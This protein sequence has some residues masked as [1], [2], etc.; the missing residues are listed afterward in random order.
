MP[1]LRE[2][3]NNPVLKPHLNERSIG[4]GFKSKNPRFA[5]VEEADFVEQVERAGFFDEAAR[6]FGKR[7]VGESE[8]AEMHR[9]H[10]FCA[11]FDKRLESLF[12]IHVNIA[13]GRGVVGADGQKRDLDIKAVSDF[14]ESVKIRAVAAVEQCA[15][16]IL[17]DESAEAAVVVVEDACAPVAGGS[18]GDAKGTVLKRFPRLELAD[19]I[20]TKAVNEP[21][22]VLGHGDGLV[23]RDR[24]QG[25]AVEMV[26]VRV[27]DKHKV[28]GR[29]VVNFETRLLDT[30]DDLEPL[31]PIGIDED[32]VLGGL[33]QERG[34]TNPGNADLPGDEVGKRGF[35]FCAVA[36]RE[37]RGYDDLRKKIS[38][39]P[40]VAEA[41]VNMVLGLFCRLPTDQTAH[42]NILHSE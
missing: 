22:D 5:F 39:V 41:H 32:A 28:D 8:G 20:K 7:L 13:F 29:E 3:K 10:C 42:H 35:D 23:A 34:V 27:R 1:G 4:Y 14:F 36:F 38:L 2:R 26:K 18:E 15:S 37:K 25:F 19:V 24:A 21:S 12:G 9:D 6:R 40:A 30:F 17:D 16:G 33:N 11:E 31:G